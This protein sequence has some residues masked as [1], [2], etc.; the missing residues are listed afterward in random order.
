MPSGKSLAPVRFASSNFAKSRPVAP[1]KFAF[2]QFELRKFLLLIFELK[3]VRGQSS[4][5]ACWRMEDR[6]DDVSLI[7]P[8]PKSADPMLRFAG[9]QTIRAGEQSATA[10]HWLYPVLAIAVAPSFSANTASA[11]AMV[12][13]RCESAAD[14]RS[15]NNRRR[16]E[17]RIEPYRSEPSI[18]PDQGEMLTHTAAAVVRMLQAHKTS[19]T[20]RRPS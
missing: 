4:Y 13:F 17:K 1:V 8:A 9:A 10:F 5:L 6:C 16:A 19:I 3:K 7:D 15:R 2:R 20:K 11:K 18:Y 14:D 12:G